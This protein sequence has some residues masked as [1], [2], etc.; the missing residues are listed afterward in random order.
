[1]TDI[2]KLEGERA[3]LLE[4]LSKTG[5]MRRGTI[6]ETYRPCG[7]PTCACASPDHP[8]HGPYYAFT[9]KVEG[10]TKSLQMRPGPR[11]SKM[12]REVE[13]Y[14][15]FRDTCDRLLVVNESLCDARPLQAPDALE[16]KRRSPS[17]SGRSSPPKSKR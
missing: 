7:K 2:P 3:G 6:T 8:G 11:L 16:K 1:M 12:E 4:R 5:D 15:E 14:K 9:R 13:T 17:R 10:K